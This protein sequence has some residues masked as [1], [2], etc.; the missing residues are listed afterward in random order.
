MIIRNDMNLSYIRAFNASPD[1]PAVDIYIN[2]AEAFK[3]L[4]FKD[5]TEYITLPMGEYKMEVYQAG[6]NETPVLTESIKVGEQEV[7]TIVAA[8]NYEDLQ[9]VSYVEGN[10]EDL[11]VNKSKVRIIHLSPDSP[12]VDVFVNGVLAFE[13]VGFLDATDYAQLSSGTYEITVNLADTNDNVLS[14]NPELKSQKVY[15]IYIVGNPPNLSGIQSLDG[16]TFIRF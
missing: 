16:S 9:L 8:G 12:N 14:L 15:T 7:I 10:A 3:N 6:Q 11:P 2:G 4:K 5:F 1:A 13:D